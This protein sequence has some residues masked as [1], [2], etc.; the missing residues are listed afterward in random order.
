MG[1]SANSFKSYVGQVELPN[2]QDSPEKRLFV[3]VLC[4][5]AHDCFSTHVEK[6]D[7]EQARHFF[8]TESYHFNIICELA[9]RNPL[10]VRDKIVKMI[11]NNLTVPGLNALK[12]YRRD[13][14]KYKRR[15]HL[16]GNAYYAAKA[17]KN[18]Y[19][20]G[21]GSKGGRPRMYNKIE[22]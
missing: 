20:E 11:T 22:K 1:R 17:A 15:K 14:N 19:Y 4:Q 18:F 9:D 5:A 13:N 10:Y 3:A 2:D 8:L 6:Q 21:M 7:K 12:S 16:T